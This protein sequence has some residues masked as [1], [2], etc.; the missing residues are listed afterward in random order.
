MKIKAVFQF[1]VTNGTKKQSWFIDLKT[2]GVVGTGVAPGKPD[3]VVSVAD[4][5]FV[6]IATGK[7]NAQKAFM[8]GKIKVK[9][10]MA[11]A[12]KLDSVLKP[13]AKL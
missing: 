9:G 12:M 13:S 5:D 7:Q 3:L 2:N 4:S 11:L 8:S 1:D 10:N 6:D